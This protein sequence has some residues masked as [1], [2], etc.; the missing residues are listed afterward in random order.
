M[1]APPPVEEVAA[2]PVPTHDVSFTTVPAGAVVRVN[3]EERGTSPVSV[4]LP[5]G[6]EVVVTLKAPG[7]A[8]ASRTITATA[9]RMEATTITTMT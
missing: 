1:V 6:Q 8:E 7:F 9:T 5:I 3:G 2:A 4:A